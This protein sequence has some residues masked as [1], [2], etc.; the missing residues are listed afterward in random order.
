MKNTHNKRNFLIYLVIII[1]IFSCQVE[2]DSI[3][4][5]ANVSDLESRS[6]VEN[7]YT[8]G[9]DSYS[10]NNELNDI[11]IADPGFVTPEIS[12]NSRNVFSGNNSLKW[13]IN[14][15]NSQWGDFLISQENVDQLIN[16]NTLSFQL[17]GKKNNSNSFYIWFEIKDIN[18]NKIYNKDIT[19]FDFSSKTWQE[20]TL[21]LS[22][23]DLSTANRMIIGIAG[24]GSGIIY[25]D[26]ILGAG[27]STAVI[28]DLSFDL[29]NKSHQFYGWGG[30]IWGTEDSNYPEI[31]TYR[32]QAL[33]EL[34][35]KNVRVETYFDL[36]R[37]SWN[38]GEWSELQ[39]LRDTTDLLGID[40]VTMVWAAPDGFTQNSRLSDIDGFAT[41][42][43]DHVDSLYRYG[44]PVEYIE[45]MNEPDSNGGWSTGISPDQYNTLVN[46]VRTKLDAKGYSNVLIVGPGT[47]SMNWSNPDMY[48]EALDS[49]G[50]DAI[51][52]LSTHMWTDDED[53][54]VG[55]G[56]GNDGGP[57]LEYSWE[58]YFG[59][60]YADS[61]YK[62]YFVT[63]YATK[64]NEFNGTT[65]PAADSVTWN[66]N[67]VFP[68]YNVTNTNYFAVRTFE[69]TLALLNSGANVPF[70]WQLTDNPYQ[71]LD[72][73]KGWGLIDLFG[74][75]KPVYLSLKTLYPEIPQ[76]A[77]VIESPNM[78]NSSVYSAV[79]VENSKTIIG[80]TNE[81]LIQQTIVIELSNGLSGLS[82]V[83]NQAFES[84][85][86]GNPDTG[87][88]DTGYITS[89][90]S[91]LNEISS[92]TYQLEIKI[93]PM[94]TA[95]V[96]LN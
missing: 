60:T 85:T 22:Q 86:F 18:N 32:E 92:G 84:L 39:H 13:V 35:I 47:T 49:S 53:D 91:T 57:V 77:W 33:T 81:E 12:L 89:A 78:D 37:N 52:A 42:W 34:N 19:G 93:S 48:I 24:S 88:P 15:S 68:Y 50:R 67:L 30:Q 73:G 6:L 14:T 11:W 65:Y 21:D 63:E 38:Y 82:I 3:K 90:E 36:Y 95:V 17:M 20:I 80:L 58:T 26:D 56:I 87:T 23:T 28:P 62:P 51:G 94:S 55:S 74:D 75:P 8:E 25:I 16:C 4:S 43:A 76:G 96:V 41:W 29:S 72:K 10:N 61:L 2:M 59:T 66:Y 9:F 44:I 64:E 70:I 7:Y 71:V 45:L 46:A 5:A 79:F 40:W 1:S 83:K 54:I 27:D 69:N 31:S